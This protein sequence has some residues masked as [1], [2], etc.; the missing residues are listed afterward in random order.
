MAELSIPPQIHQEQIHYSQAHESR[1]Y[2]PEIE[3]YKQG[4][5]EVGDGHT[6]Y[7]E[8]CGNS[9][10]QPILFLHGGPGMGTN[11]FSRRYFD[12][13][14]YRIILLDQRG[15][16]KSLPHASLENNTTW[17]LVKDIE[18]LRD[19]L[20][21]ESWIVFG[22]SWGSTLA[23]AYAET[24]PKTVKGL[25]LRGIFL[26]RQ[27]ELRWFYQ[28]GAHQLFPEAWEQFIAPIPHGEHDNLIQAY[29]KRL[30]G[31]D[32]KI[33]NQAAKAWSTWEGSVVSLLFDPKLFQLF[34]KNALAIARTECHYFIN[35][36]F[37]PTDNWLLENIA[38]IRHIPCIIVHGRYDIPCPV[39]NAW[40]L[41]K[42]W[43]EAKL[44]IIPDAGHSAQETGILDAL[45]RATDGFRKL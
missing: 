8:E 4:F 30:T 24:Y 41:H 36:C 23:L 43:P 18:K 9:K 40:D 10:G 44:E 27:Q 25:I 11:P 45:I 38:K 6:L 15:A 12:P 34:D 17:D 7:W 33:R 16:G 22:G 31:Q 37:F 28:F 13:R 19:Y 42:A 21:I 1:S 2:Y 26:S 29:Y 14:H 20:K 3:P 32:E 39:E 5:L 35:K